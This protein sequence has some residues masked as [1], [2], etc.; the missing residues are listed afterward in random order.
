MG[1]M[2]CNTMQ[3][4]HNHYI[5]T[6]IL[7]LADVFENFR[8]MSLE[9]FSLDPIHYYSVPGLSSDTMVKYT[10][11]EFDLITDT[12]MYQKMERGMCGGISNIS[13]RYA[14]SN[15]PNIQ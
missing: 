2:K 13:H 11:V 12:D 6:D 9:T 5:I 1:N 8:K 15:N 14:T 7:L 10:G 4:Y 3:D